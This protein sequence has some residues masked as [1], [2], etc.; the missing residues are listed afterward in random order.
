A[1]RHFLKQFV[2]VKNDINQLGGGVL[3]S[4]LGVFKVPAFVVLDN[5]G[6]KKGVVV[7][8]SASGWNAV[9]RKLQEFLQK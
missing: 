9:A 4:Q 3:S 7:Y 6:N 5:K 2:C 8:S 1:V